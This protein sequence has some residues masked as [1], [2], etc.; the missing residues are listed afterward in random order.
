MNRNQLR[1]LK[2]ETQKQLT[3][4]EKNMIWFRNWTP[5]QVQFH[6]QLVKEIA[7]DANKTIEQIMDSCF[8]AA[9]LEKLDITLDQCIEVCKISDKHMIE[10]KNYIEKEGEIYMKKV[11]NEELRTQIRKE[12]KEMLKSNT[13]ATT[14]NISDELKKEY[15]LPLKD[16]HIIVAEARKEIKTEKVE[17]IP[18][19]AT[20]KIEK[21]SIY[22]EGEHGFELPYTVTEKEIEEG[23]NVSVNDV[24]RE[25]GVV[26][27]EFVNPNKPQLKIKSIEIEGKYGVYIKGE[28]GVKTV[29][30]TYKDMVEVEEYKKA[31]LEEIKAD[32][33]R[34]EN[35]LSEIQCSLN[36]LD[37]KEKEEL[38]KFAEISAV[39]NM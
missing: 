37:G 5:S 39:F 23:R 25:L 34:L 31:T 28:N 3:E 4:Q 19:Q 26:E 6:K 9:M 1:Q 38:E 10:T 13:K 27:A 20:G 29:L 11:N 35:K 32:R 36:K 2:K 33:E 30:T 7:E 8:I 24:I 17:E 21:V 16:L 15:N 12:A 14:L 22:N 18:Q